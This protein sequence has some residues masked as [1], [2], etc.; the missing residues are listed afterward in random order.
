M[1]QPLRRLVCVRF[2]GAEYEEMREICAA[3][4]I[5]TVSE[6]ARLAIEHWLANGG[7][8]NGHRP[9]VAQLEEK[10]AGLAAD[11]AALAGHRNGRSLEHGA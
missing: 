9:N 10:L 3:A 7:R 5:R 2:T 8:P 6:V 4:R 1:S 11:I